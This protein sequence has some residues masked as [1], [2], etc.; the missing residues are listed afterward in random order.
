MT[1]DNPPLTTK[2]S[3]EA[4]SFDTVHAHI[5]NRK[6]LWPND[7][8]AAQTSMFRMSL[9]GGFAD[10][11][12]GWPLTAFQRIYDAA[13]ERAMF[14]RRID[15]NEDQSFYRLCFVLERG[16][17]ELGTIELDL[18]RGE[19]TAKVACWHRNPT[20]LQA[21]FKIAIPE[22]GL[23]SQQLLEQLCLKPEFTKAFPS[24]TK[25]IEQRGGGGFPPLS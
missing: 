6:A 8:G 15:L 9:L 4:I 7:I 25:S 20:T 24:F 12:W 10:E 19:H 3:I 22:A 11:H 23:S 13:D 21:E 17:L 16:G 18:A 5:M 14:M 1:Q 2:R